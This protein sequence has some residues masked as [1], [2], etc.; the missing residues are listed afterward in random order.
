LTGYEDVL[1]KRE[2]EFRMNIDEMNSKVL[3]YELKVC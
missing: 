2:H 3:E 1:K